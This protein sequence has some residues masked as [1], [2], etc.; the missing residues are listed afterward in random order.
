MIC[1]FNLDHNYYNILE[2]VYSHF[3]FIILIFNILHLIVSF[4]FKKIIYILI[5]LL[6]NI[7]NYFIKNI[8]KIK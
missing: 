5:F 1:L 3:S 2:L 8:Q 4:F 7:N 6:I